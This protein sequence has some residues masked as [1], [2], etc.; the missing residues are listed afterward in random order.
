MIKRKLFTVLGLAVVLGIILA[1]VAHYSGLPALVSNLGPLGA[2]LSLVMGLTFG[3]L[4][5]AVPRSTALLGGAAIGAGCAL[6][7]ITSSVLLGDVPPPVLA[8]GTAG[9]AVAGVVGSL[10]GTLF[11]GAKK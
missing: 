11:R 8:F 1:F 9:G 7:G 6:V 2:S 4:C 5:G 10:L 3:T